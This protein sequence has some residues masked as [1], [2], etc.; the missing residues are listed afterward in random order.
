MRQRQST[1]NFLI[2]MTHKPGQVIAA[3]MDE[4]LDPA[5][6]FTCAKS[7]YDDC[8]ERKEINLSEAYQ[9]GDGFMREVMRV[10]NEFEK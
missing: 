3:A 1:Q 6:V 5:A 9:G 8:F 2:G 7:L 10:G 4:P